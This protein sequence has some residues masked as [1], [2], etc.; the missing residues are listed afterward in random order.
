[1]NLLFIHR[2]IEVYPDVLWH[3][4]V[5]GRVV[6]AGVLTGILHEARRQCTLA[7]VGEA[8]VVTIAE[9]GQVAVE[10]VLGIRELVVDDAE[11]PC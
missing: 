6:I 8:I 7:N 2:A 4:V 5:A 1:M 10:Q 11:V 3:V 9:L